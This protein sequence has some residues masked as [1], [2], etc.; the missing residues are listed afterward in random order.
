MRNGP[1]KYLFIGNKSA[2]PEMGMKGGCLGRGS[3][4][5]LLKE[6]LQYAHL[7]LRGEAETLFF[8]PGLKKQNKP[9]WVENNNDNNGEILLRAGNVQPF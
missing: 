3:N 4:M 6:I 2:N 7:K 9:S 8:V 1:L 5:L